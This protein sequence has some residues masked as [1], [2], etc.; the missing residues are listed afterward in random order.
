VLVAPD[1]FQPFRGQVYLPQQFDAG[2]AVVHVC[3]RDEQGDGQAKG[4]DGQ[5]P[6]APVDELAA[7]EPAVQADKSSFPDALAVDR[8]GRRLGAPLLPNP[9]IL[10]EL[11]KD[12]G[13]C[14]VPFPLSEIVVDGLPR[15]RAFEVAPLAPGAVELEDD[16][17]YAAQ[18]VLPP[19]T[20][21]KE[22]FY[23]FPLGIGQLGETLTPEREFG[24]DHCDL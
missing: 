4:V 13:P 11:R 23:I 15:E 18:A 24:F 2:L 9:L 20:G 5:V 7:V 19:P 3:G 6:L 8:T 14:A 22:N 1:E 10:N 17:Q 16:I 21:V 12:G